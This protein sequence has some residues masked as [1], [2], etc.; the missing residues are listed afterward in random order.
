MVIDTVGIGDKFNDFYFGCVSNLIKSVVFMFGEPRDILKMVVF[1]VVTSCRMIEVNAVK[2]S[3][4]F[5]FKF[6]DN[7]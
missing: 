3:V 1:C 6:H 4:R 5:Y 2:I 7:R